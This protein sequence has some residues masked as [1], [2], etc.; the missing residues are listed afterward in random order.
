[1]EY[2]FTVEIMNEPSQAA[3]SAMNAWLKIHIDADDLL[4]DIKL[5]DG[6]IKEMRLSELVKYRESQGIFYKENDI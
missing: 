3:M 4:A 6:T 2:N 1:M 5:E